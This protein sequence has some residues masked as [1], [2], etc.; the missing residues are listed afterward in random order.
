M[1]G[2]ELRPGTVCKI[3]RNVTI[4]GK[5][6]FR[7]GVEVTVEAIDPDPQAPGLKYVVTSPD[8]GEKVK[9]KG[10]DLNRAFCEECGKYL[11]PTEFECPHCGWVI[12]GREPEHTE[13]ELEEYRKK[14]RGQ[15][16][17]GGSFPPGF[18]I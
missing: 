14:I 2:F 3:A 12:P 15:Q 16:E 13:K 17:S 9:L 5:L 18:P 8:T 7:R 11:T 6:T 10:A 4:D 1:L